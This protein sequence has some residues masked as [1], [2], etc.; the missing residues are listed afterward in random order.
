LYNKEAWQIALNETLSNSLPFY[1][2]G[3]IGNL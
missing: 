2:G 1:A 3:D